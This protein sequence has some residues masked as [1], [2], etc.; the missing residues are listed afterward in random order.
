VIEEHKL[1][2]NMYI[3]DLGNVVRMFKYEILLRRL[4]LPLPRDVRCT[5]DV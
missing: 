1:D 3:Y 2:D 4:Q 5:V